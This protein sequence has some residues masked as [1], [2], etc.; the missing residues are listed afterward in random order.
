MPLTE[1]AVARPTG[2]EPVTH[3]LEIRWPY[4]AAK[5]KPSK[6]K[7]SG[8]T[9]RA[10][11]IQFDNSIGSL[12]GHLPARGAGI[13][14]PFP[15]SPVSGTGQVTPSDRGAGEGVGGGESLSI[16]PV[17]RTGQVSG[18]GVGSSAPPFRWGVDNPPPPA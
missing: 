2:L 3:G 5:G 17:K 14:L 12:L 13:A 16:S 10:S 18:E 8:V 1:A 7:G 15:A 6:I 11:A 9:V 4:Q